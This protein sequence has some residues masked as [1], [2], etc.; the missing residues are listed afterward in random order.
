MIDKIRYIAELSSNLFTTPEERKAYYESLGDDFTIMKDSGK[1]FIDERD[2]NIYSLVTIGNQ[3]WLGEN[4]RYEGNGLLNPDNPSALYG[5][6][7]NWNE[8]IANTPEG[9]RLPDDNDWEELELFLGEEPG[10][11]LKSKR[12]NGTDD[13]EFNALPVGLFRVY[14]SNFYYQGGSVFFW[15]A[16]ENNVY[17]T[18]IW[19]LYIGDSE[20]YHYL[21]N[22]LL[23]SSCRYLLN[24]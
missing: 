1:M 5:R 21:D 18:G 12:W 9:F 10:K 3:T 14:D 4:L 16:T 22:K 7:Y 20:M 6:L 23:G 24:K 8:A 2:W 13:F 17:N 19:H 15:S 11:K